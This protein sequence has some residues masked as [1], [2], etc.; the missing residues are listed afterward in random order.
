M[1]DEIFMDVPQMRDLAKQFVDMNGQLD[2]V[3]KAME[4]QIAV[5]KAAAFTGMV[6][7]EAYRQW[8]ET[9]KPRVQRFSARCFNMSVDLKKI[10]DAYE[11]GD[12]QGAAAFTTAE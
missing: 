2:G 12:T 11:K 3:V 5:L 7:A 10:T 6:G 1:A 4:A 8:L 9:M